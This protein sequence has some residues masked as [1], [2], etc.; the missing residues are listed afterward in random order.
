MMMHHAPFAFYSNPKATHVACKWETK[1]KGQNKR[2]P[3]KH[4]HCLPLLAEMRYGHIW[5]LL[6]KHNTQSHL[7][8]AN[9]KYEPITTGLTVGKKVPLFLAARPAYH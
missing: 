3:S 1:K 8:V 7:I 5:S 9:S 2:I 4:H 6:R